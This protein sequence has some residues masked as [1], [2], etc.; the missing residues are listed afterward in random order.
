MRFTYSPIQWSKGD[1]FMINMNH[2]ILTYGNN[3]YGVCQLNTGKCSGN[4]YK[5]P[6]DAVKSLGGTA[7]KTITTLKVDRV[8][9]ND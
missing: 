3:K 4:V 6:F 9:I 2:Y 8:D 1:T 7:F 5:T